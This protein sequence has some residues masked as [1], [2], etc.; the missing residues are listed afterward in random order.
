MILVWIALA[1]ALAIFI[2]GFFCGD[3]TGN[4]SSLV[5]LF[6][7]VAPG[8][9]GFVIALIALLVSWWSMTAAMCIASVSLTCSVIPPFQGYGI[10]RIVELFERARCAM[11]HH[12]QPVKLDQ[13]KAGEA[14]RC[15]QCDREWI[16]KPK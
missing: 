15:T 4:E 1:V 10:F 5:A 12:E 14:F 3:G 8:A 16:V 9:I 6:A 7:V 2:L 11:F 13:W